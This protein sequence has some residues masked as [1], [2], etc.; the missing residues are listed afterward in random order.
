M[1]GKR[2]SS[3]QPAGSIDRARRRVNDDR[4][5]QFDGDPNPK[6][7][8]S[9]LFGPQDDTPLTL[10]KKQGGTPENQKGS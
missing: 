6:G 3:S 5:T 4:A 8:P 10:K 7:A 9:G 1:N 2:E